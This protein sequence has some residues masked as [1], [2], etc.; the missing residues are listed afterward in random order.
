MVADHRLWLHWYM[1][2]GPFAYKV[3]V[4]AATLWNHILGLVIISISNVGMSVTN[5]EKSKLQTVLS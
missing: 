4:P 2:P 5:I 1:N 3:D